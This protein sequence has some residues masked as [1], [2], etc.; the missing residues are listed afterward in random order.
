MIALESLQTTKEDSLANQ[1]QRESFRGSKKT[2][3]LIRPRKVQ[4]HTYPAEITDRT[5]FFAAL[6]SSQGCV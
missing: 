1:P 2:R 3:V 4:R 5:E 6:E